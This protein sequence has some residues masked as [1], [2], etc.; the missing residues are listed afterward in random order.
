M[1][2]TKDAAKKQT[3]SQC[4]SSLK[5][6]TREQSTVFADRRKRN[7]ASLLWRVCVAPNGVQRRV[8]APKGV[9]LCKP[10]GIFSKRFSIRSQL[11]YRRSLRKDF[12]NE[13]LTLSF[14][15]AVFTQVTNRKRNAKITAL[16]QNDFAVLNSTVCFSVLICKICGWYCTCIP[17]MNAGTI[18][19]ANLA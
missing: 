7:G 17:S 6:R 9:P 2:Y 16:R 18:S 4:A 3:R 11:Q 5:G 14:L 12:A 19:A 8:F 1:L 13:A 15:Y 10:Q